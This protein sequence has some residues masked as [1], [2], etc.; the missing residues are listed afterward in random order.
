LMN[1]ER[2]RV[3]RRMRKDERARKPDLLAAA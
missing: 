1:T 2:H 3:I